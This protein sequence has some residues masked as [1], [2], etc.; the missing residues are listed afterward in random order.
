MRRVRLLEVAVEEAIEAAAW[1]ERERPGL[2]FAFDSALNAALDL[3]QDEIV[4]LIAAH[5]ATGARGVLRL[6]LKRFP[7]DLV[8]APPSADEFLVIAIA[9]QSRRPEYWKDRL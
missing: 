2:G 1:Y 8:V 5:G 7:Y 4:P 3:L 6:T 9:H